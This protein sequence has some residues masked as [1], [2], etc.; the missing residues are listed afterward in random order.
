[1]SS[2]TFAAFRTVP[3]AA[4]LAFNAK[5]IAIGAALFLSLYFLDLI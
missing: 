3:D 1:M 4:R 5:L 2:K